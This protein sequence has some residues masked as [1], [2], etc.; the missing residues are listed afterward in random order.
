MQV[1]LSFRFLPSCLNKI[2]ITNCWI[3]EVR[4]ILC[5]NIYYIERG[6]G[7][8]KRDREGDV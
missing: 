2:H 8:S 5:I 4:D 6:V 1:S 7:G 3:F